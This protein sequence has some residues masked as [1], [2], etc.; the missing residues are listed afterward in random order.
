MWREEQWSH[1]IQHF[2]LDEISSK[3]ENS[4]SVAIKQ[5]LDI[6]DAEGIAAGAKFLAR[7]QGVTTRSV[8]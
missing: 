6:C 2:V 8:I 4:N 5:L 7:A 1:L 3:A